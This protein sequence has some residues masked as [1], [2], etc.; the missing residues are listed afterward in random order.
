MIKQINVI[1][2]RKLKNVSLFFSRGINFIAGANGTCKSSILHMVSNSFQKITSTSAPLE[3]KKCLSV[4]KSINTNMNPKIESLTRGDKQYRD[5]ARGTKGTL[6]SV[7]YLDDTVLEFRK[8]NSDIKSRYAIKPQYS[9]GSE[10]KLPEVPVVYLGLSR[11]YPY[12]EYQNDDAVNKIANDLPVFYKTEMNKLYKE[13][14]R[15]DISN[16]FP[17][18]MKDIKVRA[19]FESNQEGVDSNTIS[20]GEENIFI[21]LTGLMSLRYYFEALL[22]EAKQNADSILLIDEF[23]ATLHP[24]LQIKLLDIMREYSKDYHIQIIATTHSLTLLEHALRRGDNVLYLIDNLT[25]IEVMKDP[26]I[27][28][29]KMNLKSLMRRDIYDGKIIP[30]FTEDAEARFFLSRLFDYGAKE[31]HGFNHIRNCFCLVDAN[32]GSGN[33][34]QI[35]RDANLRPLM[36]AICIL[37]GDQSPDIG[38]HIISLP[39]SLSP[40]QLLLDYAS[41]LCENDDPFWYTEEIDYNGCR[42]P[43]FVDNIQ[44]KYQMFLE[45]QKK[46]SQN[47]E[48]TKG[49]LRRFLKDLWKDY[50]EFFELLVQHWIFDSNNQEVISEF[51]NNLKVQF[52]K[53]AEFHGISRK[54][55]ED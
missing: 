36:Q 15:I 43:F 26:D 30:V 14:T 17:Q 21:I 27:Y 51:F 13:L 44:A 39:G 37:D 29:I 35:F 6:Y 40:E 41:I 46:N 32:L 9:A 54:D 34:R 3:D 25:N 8:H 48:E 22:E 50:P 53:T 19:E 10:D 5:P 20:S 45:E 38:K 24:A 52:K 31:I 2:Y 42:K 12:G 23:D 7:S 11:L 47:G 28:R 18:A 1:H 55:W 49:K 16:S 33:L 4:I